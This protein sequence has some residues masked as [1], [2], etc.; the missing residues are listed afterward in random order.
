[1]LYSTMNGI[2]N[3]SLKK[4]PFIL[5]VYY[6]IECTAVIVCDRNVTEILQE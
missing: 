4:D 1:M 2:F 3:I 6:R 5:H